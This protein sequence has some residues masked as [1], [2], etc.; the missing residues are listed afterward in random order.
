MLKI[1]ITALV[2]MFKS[3]EQHPSRTW[4]EEL[5]VRNTRQTFDGV[6]DTALT[7]GKF[8]MGDVPSVYFSL[9]KTRLTQ[10][11]IASVLSTL[12]RPKASDCLSAWRR[13]CCWLATNTSLPTCAT[14]G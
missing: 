8:D 5:F 11:T 2:S 14:V 4:W 10:T 13:L 9:L 3:L 1:L 12:V 7:T 6:V